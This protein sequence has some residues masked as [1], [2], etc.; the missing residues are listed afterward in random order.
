[1]FQAR[2]GALAGVGRCLTAASARPEPTLIAAALLL[3]AALERLSPAAATSGGGGGGGEA[4]DGFAS[5]CGGVACGPE[6][7]AGLLGAPANEGASGG[8]AAAEAVPASVG[9]RVAAALAAQLCGN[10]PPDRVDACARS[11]HWLVATGGTGVA[12]AASAADAAA[13]RP[14]DQVRRAVAA[15]F[16]AAA[17]AK[18]RDCGDG[19]A[20]VGALALPCGA[21]TAQARSL[22]T[23]MR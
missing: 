17:A 16:A 13:S 15:A 18:G 22:W 10:C 20:L 19:S 1:M 8:A 4:A 2:G 12:F 7:V 3:L 9:P 5:S 6:V 11:L 21:W 23:A 14:R